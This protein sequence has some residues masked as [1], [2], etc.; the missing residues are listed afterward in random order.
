MTE[1]LKARVDGPRNA[2]HILSEVAA[3]MEQHPEIEMPRISFAC[4]DEDAIT[5]HL[6]NVTDYSLPYKGDARKEATLRTMERQFQI[7][8]DWFPGVAEWVAND[9]SDDKPGT[10]YAFHRDYYIL[11]GKYR[12]ALIKIMCSREAVG[13]K[14]SVIE[15]GPSITKVDGA[16]RSIRQTATMWR[17]N[18]TLSKLSTP[19]YELEPSV[20]LQEIES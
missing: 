10:A 18:I 20:R 2:A 14:V 3:L 4:Y 7:V 15:S 8:M 13:E 17:P 1:E 16:V 12:G 6:H 9:P 11:T 19:A 5:F